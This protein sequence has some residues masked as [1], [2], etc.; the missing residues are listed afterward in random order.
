[1][2]YETDEECW[3]WILGEMIFA[4]KSKLYDWEEEFIG[5]WDMELKDKIEP[6]KMEMLE[7]RE[8]TYK[9]DQKG[10]KKYRDPSSK[11]F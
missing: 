10:M 9:V 11:W 1:M 2:Q 4:F 6:G 8:S 3:D 7:G 5:V